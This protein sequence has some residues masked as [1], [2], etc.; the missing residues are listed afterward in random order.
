MAKKEL[1]RG[2]GYKSAWMVIEGKSHVTL[3]R[4]LIHGGKK[5]SYDEGIS[6][7]ISENA[8]RN[9]IAITQK[10]ANRCYVAGRGV[11]GFFEEPESYLP[12]LKEYAKVYAYITERNT[13]TH[14]FALVE[15]GELTRLYLASENGVRNIGEPSEE[16]AAFAGKPAPDGGSFL[17]SSLAEDDII[18]LAIRQTGVT[19][20]KYPYEEVF[21][22]NLDLEFDPLMEYPPKDY[23]WEVIPEEVLQSREADEMREI[24]KLPDVE[25]FYALRNLLHLWEKEKRVG[26]YQ[27]NLWSKLGEGDVPSYGR[28]KDRIG[29]LDCMFGSAYRISV[30]KRF[31]EKLK[32]KG[33][34]LNPTV[35]IRDWAEFKKKY[36]IGLPTEL[37]SLYAY[38]TN[39]CTMIDGFLLR[40]FEDWVF[41]EERISKPF[42]FTEPWVWE[43]E[44]KDPEKMKTIYN[45]VIELIDIGDCQRWCI[46]VK[47]EE[48][49]KMWFFTDVGIQPACPSMDFREWMEYWLNG[50]EDFFYGYQYDSES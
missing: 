46:V 41:D 28:L 33:V 47:G 2:F 4:D 49:G 6:F 1:P 5:Y 40:A 39:G 48:R 35:R 34:A 45:G 30:A 27:L 15:Y 14:G 50:G 25:K 9:A 8:D 10:H 3:K 7:V 11:Y 26:H 38:V 24:L 23:D 20:S 22:G 21:V 44:E 29:E 17:D 18:D 13:E 16:E 31:E 19:L 37:E 42:P 12:K 36:E 32:E 43:D